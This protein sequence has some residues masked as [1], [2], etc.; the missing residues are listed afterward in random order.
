MAKCISGLGKSL[1][2]IIA[3]DVYILF[4]SLSSSLAVPALVK[5][6]PVVGNGTAREAVELAAFA[7]E[8]PNEVTLE[9]GADSNNSADAATRRKSKVKLNFD[10]VFISLDV[11]SKNSNKKL[12]FL[13]VEQ[14]AGSS[15]DNSASSDVGVSFEALDVIQKVVLLLK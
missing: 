9:T 15:T 4:S 13:Q 1:D 7:A 12:D 3:E 6:E 5:E 8:D 11:C 10:K 14:S 2:C